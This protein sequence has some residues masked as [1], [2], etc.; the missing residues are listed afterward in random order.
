[1]ASAVAFCYRWLP[2]DY[3]LG[4]DIRL[5]GAA[6][7]GELSSVVDAHIRLFCRVGGV[8][9]APVPTVVQR[10]IKRE[11]WGGAAGRACTRDCGWVHVWRLNSWQRAMRAGVVR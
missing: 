10:V 4:R 7:R 2:F 1:V 8:A 3:R 9:K 11:R 5:I 6:I